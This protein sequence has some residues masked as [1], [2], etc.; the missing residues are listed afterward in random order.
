[1]K[2]SNAT[3][4]VLIFLLGLLGSCDDDDGVEMTA[5]STIDECIIGGWDVFRMVNGSDQADGIIIFVELPEEPVSNGTTTSEAFTARF[6]ATA[7]QDF[8]WRTIDN[9]I[10]F[11][12]ESNEDVLSTAFL[13]ESFSKN[14]FVLSKQLTS[15]SLLRVRLIKKN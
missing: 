13:V 15:N 7:V 11:I 8:L 6:E 4:I 10:S 12:H 9:R 2:T 5:C 3:Y 1:M 14:E